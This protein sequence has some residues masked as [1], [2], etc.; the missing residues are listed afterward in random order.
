MLNM[1]E[2]KD[3]SWPEDKTSLDNQAGTGETPVGHEAIRQEVESYYQKVS[4]GEIIMPVSGDTLYQSL[5]YDQS[6]LDQLPEE[7]RL[8]LSCGN[9][10]EH[11]FLEAGETLLDLGCG[12]GIDVF[13][14]RL[15]FPEAG[16]IY[17]MDIQPEMI[18]KAERV[19]DKKQFKNIE[20]HQGILTDMPFAD[21]SIGKIISNCVI[22]L[23][24]DKQ[25]VYDEIYRVLKPGGMFFISDITLKRELSEEIKAIPD[26]HGS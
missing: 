24:P 1:E 26:L 8:G 4:T 18:K 21:G 16:T 19:R 2:T 11:L 9:P 7:I 13:L 5:G 10:L 17:G 6:L 25:K 14:T 20:F 3:Q 23:E 15:K 22:N 12:T